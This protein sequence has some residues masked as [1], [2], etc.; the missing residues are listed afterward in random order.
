MYFQWWGLSRKEK[1]EFRRNNGDRASPARGPTRSLPGYFPRLTFQSDQ[2]CSDR[3]GG[4]IFCA[5]WGL[6]F[7]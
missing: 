7:G 5:Q 6:V 3:H 2:K 1:S 4:G